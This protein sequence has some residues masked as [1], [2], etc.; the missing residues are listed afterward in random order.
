MKDVLTYKEFVGSVHYST[1]DEVF[2]K[3]IEGLDDL[4][5]FEEASVAKLSKKSF[6]ESVDEY[7]EFCKRE[8]KAPEKSFKG[9]FNVRLNPELHKKAYRIAMA[10]GKTL[11]QFILQAVEHEVKPRTAN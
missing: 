2:F 1:D 9:S 11:N 4:V 10:E 7:I 5:T 8:N 6:K 3:K